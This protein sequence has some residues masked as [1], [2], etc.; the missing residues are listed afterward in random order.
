VQKI[1]STKFETIPNDRKR[2]CSKRNASDWR[3]GF[4]RNLRF[5]LAQICFGFR[6]SNFGFCFKGVLGARKF[7]EV[8]LSIILNGKI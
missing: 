6:Y 1:R 3:F 2:Q 7:L 4:Y 8:V 5:Y